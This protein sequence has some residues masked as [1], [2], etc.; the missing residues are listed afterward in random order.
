MK[1]NGSTSLYLVR[2]FHGMRGF[3]HSWSSARIA[4]GV[5]TQ[6]LRLAR[7]NL[8]TQCP[9][10]GITVKI[11]KFNYFMVAGYVAKDPRPCVRVTLWLV[12]EQYA[13][14]WETARSS[15]V[16]TLIS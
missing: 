3:P 13:T 5:S 14:L 1:V 15:H 16:D 11:M 2:N 12:A 4:L 9:L 10:I 8:L 6:D 7:F